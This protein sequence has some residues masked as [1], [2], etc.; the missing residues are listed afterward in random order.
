[1]QNKH[2]LLMNCGRPQHCKSV[3]HKSNNRGMIL[4]V[5]NFGANLMWI[6][7]NFIHNNPFKGISITT[8]VV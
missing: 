7:R 4:M 6:R 1:M 3:I 8:Y 2:P 5:Q